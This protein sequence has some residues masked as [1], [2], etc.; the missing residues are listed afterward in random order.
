MRLSIRNRLIRT[1]WCLLLARGSGLAGSDAALV[2]VCE[3]F[4]RRAELSGKVISVRGRYLS[5]SEEWALGTTSCVDRP[6]GP[7]AAKTVVLQFPTVNAKQDENLGSVVAFF[8]QLSTWRRDSLGG[9]PIVVTIRGHFRADPDW[10]AMMKS[11]RREDKVR[12]QVSERIGTLEV[13]SI[14]DSVLLK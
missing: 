5:G 11:D 4:S 9:S 6:D 12:R 14:A 2:S 8:K 10:F 3:L 13:V 1:G 7:S